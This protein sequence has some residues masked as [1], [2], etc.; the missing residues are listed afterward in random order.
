[1]GVVRHFD[2]CIIGSGSGNSIVD[3]R[4]DDQTVALVD[5]GTFGGTCLNVGCI[6]SK[7]YVYPAGLARSPAEA[8]RL[9]VDLEFTGVHWPAIRDRIFGRIDTMSAR[10]AAYRENSDNVT[11]FAEPARFVAAQT[12]TFG[13]GETITA[14]RFVVAAGSRAVVPDIP[15]LS[16]V[17]VPHL[18]HRDATAPAARVR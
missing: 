2:L 13:S 1:M 11:L 3:H 4:F 7:M 17:H 12:L 6:P 18:R 8:S 10:V 15:G 9:G 5:Q 14:D 16:D